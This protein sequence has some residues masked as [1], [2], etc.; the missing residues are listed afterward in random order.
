MRG[1]GVWQDW[2]R[3][4]CGRFGDEQQQRTACFTVELQRSLGELELATASKAEILGCCSVRFSLYCNHFMN[5]LNYF[6]LSVKLILNHYHHPH[7]ISFKLNM[8]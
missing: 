5:Q 4:C 6:S 8:H 3:S 1:T 2:D 7:S